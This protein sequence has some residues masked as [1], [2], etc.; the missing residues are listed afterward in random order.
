MPE[1]SPRPTKLQIAGFGSL[2]LDEFWEVDS[3]FLPAFGLTVGMEYVRDV[4]WFQTAYAKLQ[5]VGRRRGCQPGGSAANTIAALRRMGF[6]TGFYGAVG[7][8]DT[9]QM[10]L[11]DLGCAGALLIK[12]VTEPAGR[13]LS[14]IVKDDTTRDRTLVILPNA[15][16]CM[17]DWE[18][19]WDYLRSTE[20]AHFTSFV[21]EKALER[22]CEAAYGFQGKISFDPGVIYCK[23]PIDR[24]APILS[25]TTVLFTTQEEL[26][27]LTGIQDAARAAR[28]LGEIGVGA[29]VVKQ[30]AQ[31]ITAFVESRRFHQ[32]AVQAEFITD[33]TG[34]GDVAAAGYL[35]GQISGASMERRLFLAA[36]AASK[37]LEG[38]GRSAYPNADIV[39][40]ALVSSI[41][42]GL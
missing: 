18:P 14:L 28:R 16:D 17:G 30:G 4:E 6:R 37:S 1:N 24:L 21:S 7:D 12:T 20:W 39:E 36:L 2:N 32:P 42:T 35:A 23:M 29:V 26:T 33:R 8:S 10:R 19:P 34:A 5:S 40:R 13:C 15:N 9:E 38:Y 27:M 31:G 25:K 11:D 22:Q 3:S 41:V